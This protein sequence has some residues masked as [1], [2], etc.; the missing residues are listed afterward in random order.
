MG[1]LQ[2][3]NMDIVRNLKFARRAGVPLISIG[4]PDPAALIRRVAGAAGDTS[5]IVSCTA[6]GI[7]GST[8]AG[9]THTWTVDD[10][11]FEIVGGQL[12]LVAGQSLDFEAEPTVNLTIT[13]T[14]QGGGVGPK[15]TIENAIAAAN[16]N[17]AAV[18]PLIDI[19]AGTFT[20]DTAAPTK[21]MQIVGAGVGTALDGGRVIAV[22]RELLLEAIDVVDGV[23]HGDADG[24]GRHHGRAHVERDAEDAFRAQRHLAGHTV[25]RVTAVIEDA[26]QEV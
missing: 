14:D 22:L 5:P 2:T 13:A 17:G 12:R 16:A 6:T 10:V 4:T 8:D 25:E 7:H 24:D 1:E 9:D 3:R 11:R 20:P 23:V 19:G 26:G 15:L 21:T 18:Y